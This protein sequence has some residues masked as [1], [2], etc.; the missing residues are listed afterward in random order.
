[1]NLLETSRLYVRKFTP[2][3][4]VGVR[5]YAVYKQQTGFEIFDLF[6]AGA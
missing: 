2:D 6:L 1:M 5:E 3:D 4:C